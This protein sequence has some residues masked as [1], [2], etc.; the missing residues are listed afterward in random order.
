MNKEEKEDILRKTKSLSELKH[1]LSEQPGHPSHLSNLP[2]WFWED[3][4]DVITSLEN[5]AGDVPLPSRY[6]VA[7]QM[8]EEQKQQ[9]S[10]KLYTEKDL[11]KAIAFGFGVCRKEDRAPFN[12]EMI[13]F[14]GSLEPTKHIQLPSDE[15]IEDASL[16]ENNDDLSPAEE[17]QSGAKWMRDKIQG[18]SK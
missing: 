10:L 18:G 8:N 17:F 11:I 16:E 1:W 13:E 9:T 5:L 15:E 4:G 3:W 12:T 2:N 14:I 7:Q 6:V